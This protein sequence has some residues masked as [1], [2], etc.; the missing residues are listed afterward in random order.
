MTV[1]QVLGAVKS[2]LRH[3]DFLRWEKYLDKYMATYHT[4]DV[5]VSGMSDQEFIGFCARLPQETEFLDPF[6]GCVEVRRLSS[7]ADRG[8]HIVYRSRGN[9][10][11]AKFRHFPAS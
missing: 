10:L 2:F 6:D 8:L 5:E 11:F 9:C 4:T 3:E 7:L 1:E